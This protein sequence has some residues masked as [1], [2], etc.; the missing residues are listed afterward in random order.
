MSCEKPCVVSLKNM[1]NLTRLAQPS[2]QPTNEHNSQRAIG[3]KNKVTNS[4]QR[5][6]NSTGKPRHDLWGWVEN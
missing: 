6:G 5:N 2:T 1:N 4:R 3:T